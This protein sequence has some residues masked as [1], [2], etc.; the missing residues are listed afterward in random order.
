MKMESKTRRLCPALMVCLVMLA[1]VPA[2]L[3][4]QTDSKAPKS[5]V[6]R[7]RQTRGNATAQSEGEK[8]FK[9]NCS[10]CHEAPTSFSPRIAGTIL[11]HMR[12]RASLSAQDERDI[13]QFLN[14]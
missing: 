2:L 1:G 13:L 8:E 3:A 12:V 7:S 9:Q 10:R 4:L 6:P 11:R 5:V 14:P